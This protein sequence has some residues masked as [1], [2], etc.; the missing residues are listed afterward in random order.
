MS[1]STLVLGGSRIAAVRFA[2]AAPD[3]PAPLAAG[4]VLG[5]IVVEPADWNGLAQPLSS[6]VAL[7]AQHDRLLLVAAADLDAGSWEE[8]I[9]FAPP[10]VELVV[11]IEVI[12]AEPEPP[13]PEPEP[14]EPGAWDNYVRVHNAAGRDVVWPF[15]FA[16]VYAPGEIA[17]VP[18]VLV[19]GEPAPSQAD[20]LARWPDGSVKHAVLAIV[21]DL[22]ADETVT[23]SFASIPP[24]PVEELSVDDMLA[25]DF[26]AVLTFEGDGK[27]AA[28]SARE[29]LENYDCEPIT[30][31]RVAQTVM[32]GDDIGRAYDIGLRNDGYRP[33]RPRFYATF[34]SQTRQVTGRVAVEASLTGEL[35]DSAYIASL[36]VGHTAPAEVWRLDL[37]GQKRHWT[38]TC[39]TRRFCIGEPAPAEIDVDWGLA[40]LTQIG[41]VPNF[42][43][44]IAVVAAEPVKPVGGPYD[45]VWNGHLIENR[46][47]N[48]SM[49]EDIGPYHAQQVQALYPAAD[50]RMY[51]V[52]QQIGEAAGSFPMHLRETEAKPLE[53]GD[54]G[55]SGLGRMVS[56]AGRPTL[57]TT[58]LDY[59]YTKPEDRVVFIDGSRPANPNWEID[60]AHQPS[61][62]YI[63]YLVTGD[64]WYLQ[65]M[66]LWAGFSAAFYNGAAT[67][68]AYGRGPTGAEGVINDQLRGA[69]WVL[70][71]LV[72]TAWIAPD[73]DPEKALLTR[74]AHD[75]LA[76]WEGGLGIAGTIYDGCAVKEW[77]KKLG[78][79]YSSNNGPVSGRPPPTGNWESLGT[80]NGKDATVVSNTNSGIYTARADGAP[81]TGSF[82]APWMQYHANYGLGRALE[83]GWPALP[84]LAA[85]APWQT[86]VILGTPYPKLIAMYQ[87]PTERNACA[88]G[89][90][91]M[92]APPGGFFASWEEIVTAI[93]PAWLTGEGW[94]QS[95]STL[96]LDHYF[97]ANLHADGR[98]MWAAAA[99]AM[100]VDQ[101]LPGA[102][103]AWAWFEANVYRAAP[104]EGFRKNARWAV[105]PRQTPLALPPILP[106]D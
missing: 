63:P 1:A 99:L 10:L 62:C 59:S 6:N 104:P 26:D 31:G 69:G 13:E 58:V 16:R 72:E 55:D 96:D 42:D 74:F 85:A 29:M 22:A 8:R 53:V 15:Q 34:W 91:A 98:Q 68:Q 40:Y 89:A 19:D 52:M 86:G 2:P 73:R 79:Y 71:N 95:S 46:M 33:L 78:N 27:T 50:W 39:W 28:A 51:Q 20:V 97:A 65:E 48:A 64:P 57:M 76:R 106:E 101:G 41:A 18:A 24:P 5:E 66:Y 67:T 88:P 17:E 38:M 105:V 36:R 77:G 102:A 32:L 44:A 25:F 3:W 60:G 103:E 87:M 100:M 7:L 93:N 35:A 43:T 84:L 90:T 81:L 11:A 61:Y 47:G 23:L 75:A 12:A 37:A 45:G 70:R 94:D 14:P 49:R 80:P 21:L 82:T 92:T 54:A 56:I 4:T 30:R 83:L 9:L